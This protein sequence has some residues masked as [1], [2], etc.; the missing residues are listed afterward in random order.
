MKRDI[1]EAVVLN[2][3]FEQVDIIETY[4]S[5]I[6]TDRYDEAGDFEI[7]M[8]IDSGIPSNIR[9]GCYLWNADS[10]HVM[11]IDTLRIESTVEEGPYLIVSG[12]SLEKILD[13]R[14]VWQKKVF[15]MVNGVRPNL[16]DAIE[17]ILN[18]NVI[19]PTLDVRRIP[20]FIF[21]RSD[22]PRIT[23]LEIEAQYLGEDLYT[24]IK[25]LCVENEIGFKITL[26]DDNKFKFKLYAGVDRSYGTDDKPQTTNPYVIF[27]PDYNNILSSNYL[28]SDAT[29][30]NVTLVVGESEYDEDGNEISRIAY[31]WG[32]AAGLDRREIFTDATSLSMEDEEGGVLSA[33]QYQAHL[34]HKGIDTL[35]E[36]TYKEAFEGEVD[37][38]VMFKYGEDFW[39]GDIVQL[40][41]EYGLEGRACISELVIACD[42]EG[43]SIYPT[44]KTIQKGVYET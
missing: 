4:K 35:M 40:V 24:I 38:H 31:E 10:E 20:N 37:A 36:N 13:R 5:F 2:D 25:G 23:K 11:I 42:T 3:K 17:T 33:D 18:E 9:K 7:Y 27:S 15:N 34:R 21:E 29:W 39:V 44:F 6:W 16:Q 30:K 32:S 19:N 41:N 14:I 28:D 1:I 22:D 43:K 12:S 8:P 26:T